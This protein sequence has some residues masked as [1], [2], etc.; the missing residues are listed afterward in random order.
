MFEPY[1][2]TNDYGHY[3]HNS[4]DDPDYKTENL[5]KMYKLIRTGYEA[6][7]V[8]N[9]HAV[10]DLNLL[11]IDPKDILKMNIEMTLVDGQVVY[12]REN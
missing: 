5:E 4:S 12:E 7:F 3:R 8:S 1:P 9:I 10:C 2:G 11:E 6:G